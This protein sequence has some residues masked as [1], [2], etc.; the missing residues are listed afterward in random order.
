MCKLPTYQRDNKPTK[1]DDEFDSPLARKDHDRASSKS[2]SHNSIQDPLPA[3]DVS[4]VFTILRPGLTIRIAIPAQA[5]QLGIVGKI[6]DSPI[7]IQPCS[8]DPITQV[9]YTSEFC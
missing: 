1:S 7:K 4:L 3:R 6:L 5:C 8:M 9:R 2:R